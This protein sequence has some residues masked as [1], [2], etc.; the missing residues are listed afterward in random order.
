MAKSSEFIVSAIFVLFAVG[1]IAASLQLPLGTPLEPMPGFL[2]LIVSL[3]LL[4][5]SLA[6]LATA[7]RTVGNSRAG[8]RRAVE[9][10]GQRSRGTNRLQCHSRFSWIHHRDNRVVADDHSHLRTSGVAQ[11]ADHRDRRVGLQL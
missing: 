5:V 7:Y 3:F 4:F 11:A 8:A 1:C 2:P 10:A 6:Q 9:A